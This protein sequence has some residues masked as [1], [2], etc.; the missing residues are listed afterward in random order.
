MREGVQGEEP[1]QNRPGC[2]LRGCPSREQRVNVHIHKQPAG[3]AATVSEEGGSDNEKPS[4]VTEGEGGRME[5]RKEER[6]REDVRYVGRCRCL[7]V[8]FFSN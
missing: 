6:N 1:Y 3:V 5:G 4:Q 8:L 7:T 2:M